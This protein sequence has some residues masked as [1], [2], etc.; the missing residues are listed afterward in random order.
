MH[1]AGIDGASAT[2]DRLWMLRA[3]KPD[4]EINQGNIERAENR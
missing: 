2:N 1:H 4:R 3:E